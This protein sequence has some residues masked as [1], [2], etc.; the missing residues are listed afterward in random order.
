MDKQCK[1][2]RYFRLGVTYFRC[3]GIPDEQGH[4]RA[5]RN[6]ATHKPDDGCK[7]WRLNVYKAI[8]QIA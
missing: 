1:D 2:C 7:K 4:C 3:V 6:Y 8:K 5:S